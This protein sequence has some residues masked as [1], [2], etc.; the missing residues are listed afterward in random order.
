MGSF[1]KVSSEPPPAAMIR[2]RVAGV[3][4]NSVQKLCM[5]FQVFVAM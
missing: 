3:K 4:P 5:I 1:E 2:A